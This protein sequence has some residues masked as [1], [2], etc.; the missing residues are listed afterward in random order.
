M[1]KVVY[2]AG[3]W[4]KRDE[5]AAIATS[6]KTAGFVIAR[7]W[8][9]HEA[10]DT[11][12]DKLRAQAEADFDAVMQADVVLLVNSAPSAGKAF[13]MGVA[14]M[15]C[16]PIVGL[17]TPAGCIF[18]HLDDFTWVATVEEAIKELKLA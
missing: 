5:V 17:G 15:C 10:G 8:W 9:L 12:T 11:E 6:L 3:P 14:A 1:N 18:Y 4:V 13:E 2:I 16:I 7:E